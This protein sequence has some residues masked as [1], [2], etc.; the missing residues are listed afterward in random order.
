MTTLENRRANIFLVSTSVQI[1]SP[2]GI[3]LVDELAESRFCGFCF[4]LCSACKIAVF[5]LIFGNLCFVVVQIQHTL[6]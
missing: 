1:L 6:V 5:E 3:V 4:G 2:I